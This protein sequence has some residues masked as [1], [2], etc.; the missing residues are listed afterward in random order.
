MGRKLIDLSNQRFGRWLVLERDLTVEQKTGIDPKWICICDCGVTRSVSGSRLKDGGSKSCGCLAKE[1][2]TKHGMRH[3]SEYSSWLG[4]RARVKENYRQSQ[5]YAQKGIDIDPRWNNSFEEFYKDMGNKPS[6]DYSI[7]RVD[8]SKGYWKENCRWANNTQQSRNRVIATKVIYKDEEYNIGDLAD[9]FSLTSRVLYDRV[10]DLGWDIEKALTTPVITQNSVYLT[11]KGVTKKQAEWE[12][13]LGFK[14][15]LI[16]K[17]LA[18]G[19]SVEKAI[20]TSS[21]INPNRSNA[22]YYTINNTT[23]RL[24]DW[25]KHFNISATL[26]NNRLKKG[27]SVE[28]A[29]TTSKRS[30]GV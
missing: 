16:G 13:E 22:T 9:K 4:M 18:L 20:E 29:F 5:Y 8:N 1:V 27:M 6:S 25:C 23:K 11:Y 10:F 30:R 19:W 14:N 17:R 12:K 24:C 21:I 26:F 15:N 7:D 28:E 2:A 3:S